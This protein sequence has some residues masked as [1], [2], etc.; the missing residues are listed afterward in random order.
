MKKII[1]IIMSLCIAQSAYSSSEKIIRHEFKEENGCGIR[2]SKGKT[3]CIKYSSGKISCSK[4]IE[5][6]DIWYLWEEL[7]E[8]TFYKFEAEY[9]KQEG[10]EQFFEEKKANGAR[11]DLVETRA[12]ARMGCCAN[13]C[14]KFAY[15]IY[16]IFNR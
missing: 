11:V 15:L 7:P 13:W 8:D 16:K 3:T 4:S 6:G 2:F 9:N 12:V 5:C 14:N 1:C 10:L